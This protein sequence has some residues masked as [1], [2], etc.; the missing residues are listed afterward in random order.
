MMAAGASALALSAGAGLSQ[1]LIVASGS[2]FEDRNGNGRRRPGDRGIADIL[3]SNG[4]EV[5][6]TDEDGRWR[7]PVADGDCLFVIKPPNWATPI[8]PG[9]VPQFSYLHQPQGSPRD[10]DYLYRGV[11]PTG[12]L[13]SSID[14]PLRGQ[15]EHTQFEALLLA[16]TQPEDEMELAYLREDIIASLIGRSAAFAINHGDV[17]A[18]DLSLY[19]RYLELLGTT[20]IP[21]HHV[22]GNHDLNW[23]ARDDA[24]SR[25]TWK[26][27]FGPR[28]YAFQYA[29]ATFILLDNVY[30]FGRGT[31]GPRS[32]S[33]C[34]RI[35]E[36]QLGFVRGLLAHVPRDH[37]IV[38]C[39]HI[40]LVSA[41]DANNPADNTVDRRALLELLPGRPHTLSLSGHM[42]TTEHHYLGADQ[43]FNGPETHH[44]HVLTAACG[45]W[46]CGPHDR[47]GIPCADSVDG[48][49]NGLHVLSIDGQRYTT[50]FVPAAAKS[51][52][53]LRVMFAGP[54]RQS[55]ASATG[56][57]NASPIPANELE[58]CEVLVNLFDGG[59][60]STVTCE[61]AGVAGGPMPMR[62][63]TVRDP[64]IAA[65]LGAKS[66]VRKP[67]VEAMPSTHC[68]NARLPRALAPGAHRVTVRAIDEY[69]RLHVAHTV[70]EVAA[71]KSSPAI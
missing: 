25:E 71:A 38:L 60:R 7:L 20:G 27:T 53:Q 36:S 64:F 48:T 21:W 45:S 1:R 68:W 33:Y 4:R 62:R 32:G 26:R 58:V 2:V 3:V 35:G 46:W 40:P 6:K 56:V 12:A 11:A 18:D 13:P 43:G 55:A 65:L 52:A 14:F 28:H 9:G 37:L 42:H 61:I 16:D 54:E 5:V 19:P 67:W 51:S 10:T 66:A 39:M 49:P 31:V 17:V 29:Q 23:E 30:Y 50:R 24:H 22:P 59:P 44:H 34:G 70:L 57:L 63:S 8:G 15:D 69:G 41:Q 47:R